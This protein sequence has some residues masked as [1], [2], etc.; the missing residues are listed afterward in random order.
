MSTPGELREALEAALVDNPD[1]RA[2]H[3]A[4]ADHLQEQG[5]P[6]GEFIQVQL[7]LE[8]ES[9]SVEERKRLRQREAEL[10]AA[11]EKEWLGE[12]APLLLGTPDQQR[13]LFAAE[14]RNPERLEYTT[15][16]MHFRH[17]WA[18]GWLDRFECNNLTVEMARKLGRAPIAR[19]LR[20]LVCRG[21]EGAGVFRYEGGPDLPNGDGYFRPCEILACYP[22]VHNI[23]IF[24][25]G[26]E[27][28]PEEDGY[29]AGTQFD[30]LAP[31]VE[32]MPRLEELYIYGHIYLPE[33]GRADLSQFLSSWTLA[34]L[35]VF[36]HYHG[37]VYPLEVL[38]A[39]RFLSRLTHLLCFP[40]SFAPP[41]GEEVCSDG[42]NTAI[43]RANVRAVVTS[44]HL[45]ALTRLQ[46]RCCDGGDATIADVVASG[47]LKRLKM[48]DL[49][50]G[51][52]TDEGARLLASCPDA[53][54]LEVLDLINNRLTDEGIAALQAAGIRVRA[55]RQQAAPYDDQ[56]ILYYGDWE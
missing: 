45:T 25:Y 30:R 38:A 49:R 44:T 56:A 21:D 23:R 14:M 39:N 7:A 2:A 31:L 15:K 26:E 5:D 43:S 34:N 13:A 42:N 41:P 50:H 22:S 27:V 20:A 35:R 17:G 1:D 55:E 18:R 37:L 8:D 3:M 36:Q 19:L 12:L 16:C 46:L 53:K 29:H 33:D 9:R 4:Y 47:V 24:Q 54:S 51:Y 52:V 6:R 28:D 40:H 11:H 32:R 48:L 10:L